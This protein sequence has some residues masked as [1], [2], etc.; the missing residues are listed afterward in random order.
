MTTFK[1]YLKAK[2]ACKGDGET[3]V[4]NWL[5]NLKTF[6]N[7]NIQQNGNILGLLR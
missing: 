4:Q 1:G 3:F 2:K 5:N 6:D 7:S